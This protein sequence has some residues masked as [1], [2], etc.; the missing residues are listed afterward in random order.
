MP[1][2]ADL[3]TSAA[4]GRFPVPDGGWSRIAPWHR[5]HEA[6]VAFT[7]HA[8]F[9]VHDDITDDRLV[10][11]GADGLGGAHDPRLV[12]ALAGPDGWID[13]LD[14]VLAAPGT[15]RGGGLVERPDLAA[16]PRA[17]L[18]R[19]LRHDV[20]VLGHADPS[21]RAVA[22]LGRGIAGLTELS[23]E[24]EP[25]RR[26]RG[27]AA[28]FVAAALATVPAG[29]LVLSAVAPGNAASMR[30]LLAAG[31]SLLGSIQLF[32]RSGTLGG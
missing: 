3:L 25:E 1:E 21:R 2:L 8:V 26:G 22:T 27:Q 4:V 18:A 5:E 29:Q 14:A 7:A 30:T 12:S 28:A 23:F 9:A 10:A 13:S 15:G 17:R 20:R 6:V 32:T 24:L 19:R 11:L 16:H 31:F